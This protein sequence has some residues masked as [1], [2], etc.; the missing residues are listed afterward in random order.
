M[1]QVI[2]LVAL[3]LVW[4]AFAVIQ[5]LKKREIANWVN[6]SLIIFALGFRFF[7]SLFNG[8]EDGAGFNFFF[9][10]LIGLGIFFILGNLLYY[11][12]MFAGG[13]AKLLFALGAILP[14][15]NSFSVNLKIFILFLILFLF[16]GAVYGLFVSITL[17][18][19]HFKKFKKEFAKQFK[20]NKTLFILSLFLALFFIILGFSDSF[21]VYFGILIFIIPYFYFSA[22]SLDEVCMIKKISPKNLTEGDWLYNDIRIGNKTIKKSWNGLTKDEINLLKKKRYVLVRQGIPFSPAFLISF[23]ILIYFWFFRSGIWLSFGFFS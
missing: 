18:F 8:T 23:L 19:S 21:M 7:Y 6:F 17:I 5:D 20:Q 22:K 14:F 2:F 13:D 10:G 11:C 4:M 16:A 9:Q 12:R 3:A 15:S 1:F